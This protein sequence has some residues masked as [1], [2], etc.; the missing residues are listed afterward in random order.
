VAHEPQPST[1]P[2]SR[3]RNRSARGR[4]AATG[5]STTTTAS[6]MRNNE[7]WAGVNPVSIIDTPNGPEPA[8]VAADATASLCP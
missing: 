3:P 6:P 8:K 5:T 2:Q 1:T 7:T 4:S